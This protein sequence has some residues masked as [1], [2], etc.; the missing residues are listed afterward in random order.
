MHDA[1]TLNQEYRADLRALGE[2]R[3]DSPDAIAERARLV[4]DGAG[5]RAFAPA[6]PH[7]RR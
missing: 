1:L 2:C 4:R 3:G 7:P 5:S 6:R